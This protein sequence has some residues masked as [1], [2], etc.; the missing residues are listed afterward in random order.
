MISHT[1][2]HTNVDLGEKLSPIMESLGVKEDA[3]WKL[4]SLSNYDRKKAML[5]QKGYLTTSEYAAWV[6]AYRI[7]T[8]LQVLEL[9]DYVE[10]LGIG[11]YEDN[12]DNPI[13]KLE[14]SLDFYLM[15]RDLQG[16]I[17]SAGELIL[18]LSSQEVF[19]N[20]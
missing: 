8:L 10:K 14:D 9:V 16:A 1:E 17:T 12:K 18:L 3:S 4:S 19:D 2:R 13:W 11:D 7:D 5:V 6:K 20:V 15:H